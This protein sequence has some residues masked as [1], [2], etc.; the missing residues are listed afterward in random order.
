MAKY[1]DYIRV[2]EQKAAY[3]IESEEK[4]DWQS[5]IAY[6]QFNNIMSIVITSVRN[7]DVSMH[8]S[9][10]IQGTYGTGKSHAAAVIMHLLCD[11]VSEIEEY[12]RANFKGQYKA[13]GDQLLKLRENK[14]LLPIKLYGAMQMS[15]REDLAPTLQKAIL[16]GIKKAGLKTDVFQ[17]DYDIYAEHIDREPDFWDLLLSK[18]KKLQS[19]VQNRQKLLTNLR[20]GDLSTLSLVRDA[21]REGRYDIRIDSS[22]LNQWIQDVQDVIA[23]D[24]SNDYDGLFLVW[25][26]F[27]DV[28]KSDYGIAILKA[29]QEV[30]ECL[31]KTTNN[32]YFLYISHPSAFNALERE[33]YT[34]TSG[35]YHIIKYDMETVSAFHVMSSKMLIQ[36]GMDIPYMDMMRSWTNKHTDIYA[37]YAQGSADEDETMEDLRKLFPVHPATANLAAYYARQ[38]GSSSRSVFQFLG[39]NKAIHTFLDDELKFNNMETI[40]ADYLWDYVVDEFAGDIQKYGA[41]VERFNSYRLHVEAQGESY[42]KVFKGILLLNA[43]NNLTGGKENET[44]VAP[45]E[46]NI[47]DLFS[48]TPVEP[49]VDDVLNFL[50]GNSIINRLP[51][52]MFSIQFSALPRQEI[53]TIKKELLSTAFKY[54]N[55]VVHFG[56][57]LSD[58]L[59]RNVINIARDHRVSVF[60]ME[61]NEY[62]MK[63]HVTGDYQKGNPWET[64][65]AIYLVRNSAERTQMRA[66]L[67]KWCILEEFSNITLILCD[68]PFGDKEYER[69]IEY[70]ANAECARRHGYS[71]QQ[72]T[73]LK[74]VKDML[75]SWST[76][77]KKG[78]FTYFLRGE[79]DMAVVNKMT[80]TVNACISPVIFSNGPESLD[81]IQARPSKTYW[82]KAVMKEMV[83]NVLMYG[84]KKE[85]EAK[86][87]GPNAM[88]ALLLQD[89]VDQNLKWKDDIDPNHPMYKVYLFIKSKFDHTD[90][91]Q[92]F[93]LVEK[94][95]GLTEPPYGV[96][97]SAAGMGMV[98][99][100]MRYWVGKIFD[101]NGKPREQLHLIEDICALFKAW[102]EG[103]SNSKLE[104]RFETKESR[105]LT[106]TLI[107]LFGLKNSTIYNNVSSLT[108]ARWAILNSFSNK[109][110]F[111]LWSLKYCSACNKEGMST[112]IDDLL[113][114]CQETDSRNPALINSV[115]NGVTEFSFELPALI[116]T[117][118]NYRDGF[119][120]FAM[121][122]ES[123]NFDPAETDQMLDYL[124]KHMQNGVGSWSEE[125]VK[126]KLKDWRL[127]QRT[128]VPEQTIQP[129]RQ[130]GGDNIDIVEEP[131]ADD[132]ERQKRKQNAMNYIRHMKSVDA[133]KRMLLKIC[134]LNIDR[135]IDLINDLK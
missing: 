51:G 126:D 102:D 8:K 36:Q 81:I 28:M 95:K 45:S 29:L 103:K 131:K 21:L 71:D 80:T 108:D 73:H 10:W 112:V 127:S 84:T 72:D 100:A 4:G 106:S 64:Y 123:V 68:R 44:T 113:K 109:M 90:K 104:F 63:S 97:P 61:V 39:E 9:F 5:F 128:P 18:N 107:K 121:S 30:D 70:Q 1:S 115:L 34:Q 135:V 83:K 41:V 99:F 54:T 91:S 105:E 76:E 2:R 31:T 40:T 133:T 22:K 6:T 47:K 129:Q 94:L 35:R 7:K 24:T 88:M 27:T 78:N 32:S 12:V 74:N 134:D 69:F 38:A 125:E 14:R 75:K 56:D 117:E 118:E 53:E 25:D 89:S 101:L 11:P 66:Y 86:C 52:D 110:Q 59:N 26:E 116:N 79:Q 65:L 17:T 87:T 23:N 77:L 114:L 124:V 46:V 15:H 13:Q 130:G 57:T 33:Q 42:F 120:T 20:T 55:Q 50:D 37:K 43:L 60:G 82:K 58:E 111:P 62:T 49:Q 67:E 93:N 48:G 122:I 3:N 119:L 19:Y 96:Y 16:E 98:A 92:P 85:L 132:E